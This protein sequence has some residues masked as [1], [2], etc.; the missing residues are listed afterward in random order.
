ME[1]YKI[2]NLSF[3]YPD[4]AGFALSNI[5][6]TVK[7]SEFI[8]LCGQSGCG[9][10]T[11]LRMLK[12][13]LS[14]VGS[15]NGNIYFDGA[16][17]SELASDVQAAKIGFVMQNVDNQLVTDKVWHELAFGLE[18]I[19][20]KNEEIRTRVS[21]IAEF[22]GITDKFHK[23]VSELSGGEKQILNLASIMV[24][25][26]NVLILDEPTSQLDPIAASE[27]MNTLVKINREL[28]TTVILS[29]HRLE[30]AFAVADRVIVMDNGSII[31]N[32]TP[33]DIGK[34]LFEQNHPMFAALPVPVRVSATLGGDTLPITVRDGRIWLDNYIKANKITPKLEIAAKEQDS[35]TVIDIKNVYFRYEQNAGDIIKGLSLKV[36]RG[37]FR[38]IIGGNGAGKSTTLSIICGLNRPQR[39]KVS[40]AGKC[41]MLP[42]D[43]RIL[44]TQKTV[45]EDLYEMTDNESLISQVVSLCDLDGLQDSHP[46]DLSGGETQRAALAK[47]LLTQPD[48]LLLD[49][50]T[51]GLDEHFKI[52]FADIL[53]SL[54]QKGTAIVMVSHDIE[55]CAKYAD[56]C[57]MFFDGAVT[58]T[59]TP[60][61]MFASNT[62]YTT[63]ANRMAKKIIDNAVTAEDI[64]FA[65]GATSKTRPKPQNIQPYIDTVATPPLKN[66][67]KPTT[68]HKISL[69]SVISVLIAVPLTIFC[70]IYLLDDRKY[71]FISL[72]IIFEILIPFLAAFDKRKPKARELV[73]I[74][75]LC[76][77][78]VC[79]RMIF[80]M[81]PQFKPT[82]AIVIISGVS[83]GGEVGFLVGAISAFVS[84]F[85][86]GQGPWTPWQM[87]AFG[88]V[89]FISGILFFNRTIKH[90]KT[91]FCIFGFLATVIVYGGIMN[92]SS[93]LMSNAAPSL[94]AI[95]SSYALGF[96]F[97]LI[98]SVSTV[99]FMY[100]AVEPMTDKLERIKKIYGI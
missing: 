54:T 45:R 36:N 95:L 2:E 27:F 30:D 10:T 48:V 23:N 67:K 76:A 71:Y 4:S 53:K 74:S 86:F 55:F 12:P 57:S 79:G 87:F 16:N 65:C 92:P 52:K 43:P 31:A 35:D 13:A 72:L 83:L 94:G 80:Y 97:D 38:A 84:N 60:A 51:K 7:S 73:T 88:A 96:P 100:F 47:V 15:K 56:L 75:V 64:I 91:I 22:F 90:K 8:C 25:Q 93:V 50:P 82:L 3:I 78:A 62:F 5:N 70:G 24:M 33:D 85:F 63:S 37:E 42:Q 98:H 69:I 49:E 1:C 40:V 20:I 19:G 61:K 18:N 58:A 32:S 17:I 77:L 11:L 59:Q 66:E 39:G 6:F 89:G 14:P 99:I 21:E 44:F 68:R 29:E 9:K 26:P 34:L 46:Y 28:G 81:L 41:V